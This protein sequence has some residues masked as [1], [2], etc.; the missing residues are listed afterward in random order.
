VTLG[1]WAVRNKNKQEAWKNYCGNV[2][3]DNQKNQKIEKGEPE[4][5]E[6][7]KK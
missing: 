7:R 6:N 2:S 3:R 1:Q 5:L 4:K